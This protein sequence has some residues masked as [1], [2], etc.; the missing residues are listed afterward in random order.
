M[1]TTSSVAP[2]ILFTV[3]IIAALLVAT[4]GLQVRLVCLKGCTMVDEDCPRT[5]F[6]NNT[7]R[8]GIAV[9]HE[10]RMMV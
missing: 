9:D 1:S 8:P 7:K 6:L 4:E 10:R 5:R 2:K 3:A